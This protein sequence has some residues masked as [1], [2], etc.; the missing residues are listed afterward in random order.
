MISQD[1]DGLTGKLEYAET[2]H[3]I[4]NQENRPGDGFPDAA[5]HE[6]DD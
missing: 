3:A 5:L 1:L 4:R 6:P 2:I